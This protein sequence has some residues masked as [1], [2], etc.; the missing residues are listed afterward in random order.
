MVNTKLDEFEKYIRN[1]RVAVIGLGVSNEPL[2]KYLYDK[3]ARV[4]VFDDREMSNIPTNIINQIHEYGFESSFG[5]NSLSKLI[6]FDIIFR[7]PSCMPNKK[8]LLENEKLLLNINQHLPFLAD[9]CN[10]LKYYNLIDKMITNEN[11][12]VNEIWK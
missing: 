10:K 7:S 3:L 12:L 5:P 6:G 4:T 11:K 9:L 1:R 2:L 8:E